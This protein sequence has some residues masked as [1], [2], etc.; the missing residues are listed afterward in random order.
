MKTNYQPKL[1]GWG[2]GFI[3][4]Q[5]Q[6]VLKAKRQLDPYI[7]IIT[8]FSWNQA[9]Q[10]VPCDVILQPDNT[11]QLCVCLFR[12]LQL[13]FEKDCAWALTTLNCRLLNICQHFKLQT[14][15]YMSAIWLMLC[16]D[17]HQTLKPCVTPFYMYGIG[18]CK[19]V[20]TKHLIHVGNLCRTQNTMSTD[21]Q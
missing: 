13:A 1:P 9:S 21:L 2:G 7:I 5:A 19:I 18:S 8:F 17:K 15:K 3:L 6:F 11:M 20:L 4:T 16:S 10:K 12:L 14:A